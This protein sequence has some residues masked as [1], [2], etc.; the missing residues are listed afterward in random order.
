[1]KEVVVVGA[2]RTAI[3]TFGGA[4]KDYPAT[5]LMALVIKEALKRAKVQ[6]DTV[7][8][9]IVG[10]C[11]QRMDEVVT[12]RLAALKA[13]LP[14]KVPGVTIHR[15]CASAMQSVVYGAQQIM[16]GDMDIVVAGGVEVMS[17]TPYTLNDARWGKRLQHGVMSDGLWD[18]LTDSWCGLIMGLT[19]ENLAEKYSISRQEQDV[20]AL[21]SHNCAEAATKEGRFQE[22][23]VPVEIPQRKGDPIVFDKD[24]HF[25]PG[26][27]MEQLA[28]L[29]PT[30]K[31]DGTVTP[32]N[33]SGINDGA[34]ALVLTSATKAEQL[35]LEPIAR[36]VG[37]GLGAVEPELMGY[38]PVPATKQ[39]LARTGLTIEDMEL[40]ELN[41]AFAAQ[42]I[43]C[44]KLLGLN[45]EITNVNGSGIALGHPVG[46]TGARIIVSLLHE[47]RRRKNR[48]GLAT[49]C[50]GGGMGQ[51][52][53]WEM[54]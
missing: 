47:M 4:L 19:A 36:L 13:G 48:L 35:A 42:Y 1:M 10:Q 2:V 31:K 28:R 39:A 51:A 52:T 40:V 26:L 24:E 54:I 27:T 32:G 37:H 38:G 9:V 16:L 53:I 25:R 49:L 15:N 45:R 6:P 46:C 44:E 22:E 34:A 29:K 41:E 3:G 20:V 33:A 50:V 23:I 30:F 18:A 7:D 43:A 14:V 11:M 5:D 8:D 12:G 21:R 17:R